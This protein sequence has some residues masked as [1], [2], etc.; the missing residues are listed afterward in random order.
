MN[1]I[2][3]QFNLTSW[4]LFLIEKDKMNKIN[5]ISH[6]GLCLLTSVYLLALKV[7]P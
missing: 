3:Y 5:H 1:I 4:S 6:D 7:F 2:D